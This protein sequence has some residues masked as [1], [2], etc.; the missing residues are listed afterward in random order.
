MGFLVERIAG[1]LQLVD[2]W[3]RSHRGLVLVVVVEVELVERRMSC[4]MAVAGIAGM[5]D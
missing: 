1:S 5:I 2:G 3:C 4:H